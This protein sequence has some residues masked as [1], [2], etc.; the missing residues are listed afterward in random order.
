MGFP[1]PFRP[2]S[3]A[4]SG[5]RGV[6]SSSGSGN[7][8]RGVKGFDE[9]K[10]PP[11]APSPKATPPQPS[12]QT[13]REPNPLAALDGPDVIH[14]LPDEDEARH[15]SRKIKAAPA[16]MEGGLII[17]AD[18]LLQEDEEI[19]ASK[20]QKDHK[21]PGCGA[22]L[23][24]DDPHSIGYKP[25]QV[26]KQ[27]ERG[28]APV[29][30]R[31]HS[32]RHHGIV[33][34][35]KVPYEEVKEHLKLISDQSCL[36]VKIV[37]IFDF[38]GSFINDFRGITGNNPVVL[39]GNKLDLLPVGAKPER[40]QIWLKRLATEMGLKNVRSVHL[41]SA[42]SGEGVHSL[43]R[44]IEQ[45]RK[46]R[47]VY[48][49]GC[50]NVGKSTL[51]NRLI[52]INTKGPK[53]RNLITT[54]IVP[55]TTLNLI[56]FPLG[57]KKAFKMGKR[58][59]LYDT[60]GVINK[61]QMAN[62]LNMEELSITLPKRRIQPV[63]Y[64]LVPGKALFF[65]G[66]GRLDYVDGPGPLYLTLFLSK[67]LKVHPT[68][69]AKADDVMSK[70]AGTLLVPPLGEERAKQLPEF[71]AK[72]IHIEAD[73]E[74]GGLKKS[75]ADIVFSGL[76]W[77][78]LVTPTFDRD[79]HLRSLSPEGVGIFLREPLMPFEIEKRKQTPGGIKKHGKVP[80]PGTQ[81]RT[82]DDFGEQAEEEM[83]R[84]AGSGRPTPTKTE[85]EDY[86]D[87]DDFEDAFADGDDDEDDSIDEVHGVTDAQGAQKTTKGGQQQQQ[88]QQGEKKKRMSERR[89][90]RQAFLARNRNPAWRSAIRLRKGKGK[91]KGA[92][93]LGG[94][95]SPLQPLS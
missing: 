75:F 56:S 68:S 14:L 3:S 77:T 29:C 92:Q 85:E 5:A 70:H 71:I 55:G 32:L 2:P 72:D 20:K 21:C 25:P 51:I 38:S 50:T 74:R 24:S 35:L 80:K 45:L 41:I 37:D 91:D 15:K 52:S 9:T 4:P 26:L 78:S 61:H 7:G 82:R 8:R 36:V 76:G 86:D 40:I 73:E 58:A 53:K 90:R 22:T 30:Q 93:P 67:E 1:L 27:E 33:T 11:M 48:V 49:V 23:Q 95:D 6:A 19:M 47:D 60:P 81:P 66:L 89:K 88:Q 43:S 44:K 79:I 31:C 59:F 42:K 57:G 87:D 69:I 46:E 64:R 54:S 17:Q 65:G 62:L 10:Y 84:T 63:T 34:P 83:R 94:P 16:G 13:A 28:L 12:Q 18:Q 39:V